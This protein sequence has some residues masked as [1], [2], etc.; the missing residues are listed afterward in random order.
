LPPEGRQILQTVQRR[1]QHLH[2]RGGDTEWLAA[3]F[4]R[5]RLNQ[6][7]VLQP[8]EPAVERARPQPL[9]AIDSISSS[10]A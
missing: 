8:A 10:M 7:A 6:P 1:L 9:P 3:L 4:S 5:Q 2:A